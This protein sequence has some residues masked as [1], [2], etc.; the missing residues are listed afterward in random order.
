[1]EVIEPREEEMK[2]MS[3]EVSYDLLISYANN[4][5]ASPKDTKKKRLGTY[6]ERIA[7]T[8]PS[9][10]REKNKKF[11]QPTS[12]TTSIR[13]TRSIQINKEPVPK[14]Y[15]KK[16]IATKKRGKHLILQEEAEE[17]NTEEESKKMKLIGKKSK[18]VG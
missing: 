9:S 11:Y 13:V 17:T 15:A 3:Y 18:P 6:Q 14:V 5:L 8:Q 4:L 10:V 16:K 12:V 2:E 7:P 1:M